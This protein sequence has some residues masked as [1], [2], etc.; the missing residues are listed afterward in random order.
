MYIHIGQGTVLT[1]RSVIGIFDMD[2]ATSSYITREFLSRKEKE[3]RVA[4]TGNELPK[5]FIVTE[6]SGND[7]VY[8][9]IL[10]SATL[11]K[12]AESLRIE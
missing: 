5:A 1:E 2:N 6:E 11:S 4:S 9:S 12:R 3:K 7:A 10:S 8:L